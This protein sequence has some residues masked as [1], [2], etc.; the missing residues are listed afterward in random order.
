MKPLQ[1]FSSI[2]TLLILLLHIASSNGQFPPPINSV[3]N[4][5]TVKSPANGNVTIRFK[6]P[7]VGTCTTA[8][9]TQ[10]QY[11]GYV[12]LPPF[13]LAPIQQNYSINTFFWFIEARTN[14]STAPL[15]IYI[16]GGPGSSSMVGLFNE[17]GPCQVVEMAQGRLGTQA[18][19]WGWDRSTNI[20]YVDQPNE[21][22]FSY[23]TATNGSLNLFTSVI[24]EPPLDVPS[25]QPDYTFLN[26][27]FS[28]NNANTTTNTT[29]IAAHAI[30]HMLQGFLSTF[31]QYN[32]GTYSNGTTP[33]TVGINLFAESYGG[34]YGPAFATL[35][36]QQNMLRKN[37]SIFSNRTLEIRLTSLGIMQG[38][39]DDLVQGRFYPIF[40]NNNTY[41]IQALS[42]TDQQTAASSY[43][44]ADG[45]QQRIQSCRNA[46]TSQDPSDDGDVSTVN[47]ICEDAQNA[48]NNDVIGPYMA[49]GRDVYDITQTTPDP[50]PPSTYLEY[51]NYADV[52][53]AI[54]V[55]INYTESNPAVQNAFIQTGDYER[56]DQIS[57]MAYLLSLGVR[58]ALVYGDRDYICNWLG[59]E[60][61][62]FS[63]AAQ[64]PAY[65][66][67]YSAGYADIVVNNSYVG[68]AVRQY[69]NLSFSRIYDAGHL[70][71]AYQPE[72][73]F[74]VFTRIIMGSDISLGEPTDLATHTSNGTANAT[75]TSKAPDQLEPTCWVRNIDNTC[76]DDHKVM[77]QQGQGVIINGVLYSDAS[78]WK[79]PP[80]DISMSA[81]YPGTGP[82]S[83]TTTGAA[84]TGG[85]AVTTTTN[86]LTGVFTA[87]STPSMTKKGAAS[88]DKGIKVESALLGII[89]AVAGNSI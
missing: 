8:F 4:F 1:A 29:E 15:T 41:G 68:G 13:T 18:N 45:C 23:D 37:G 20:L 43:L 85:S 86:A 84:P 3:S 42:L 6:T 12:S 47:Q 53:A 69:G 26:G 49:S 79:E 54:G 88:K 78:D 82:L 28:S 74:T 63:I 40:A 32:P 38:C 51:L 89:L 19:D 16:N 5:T 7:P 83:T 64:S 58:V 11:T 57:Q 2:A 87:T 48:C 55:S 46:V 67:F 25:G 65:T 21:V 44:S 62:S 77:L 24:D 73:A 80:S 76:N 81:G 75:F 35:W 60:A 70:I 14:A 66:P 39:V 9:P 33:G 72:T 56:G 30:W 34:K 59:G 71:P 17:N 61:V 36:E 22:G 10:K 31:P 50:F 27:T 52:Q